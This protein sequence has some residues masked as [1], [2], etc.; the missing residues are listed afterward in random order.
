MTKNFIL[1]YAS[2]STGEIGGQANSFVD[3]TLQRVR[4]S[5]RV[6]D[7]GT[8]KMQEKEDKLYNIVEQYLP[9]DR[10]TVKVTG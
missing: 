6:K 7:I 3:S 10:Y 1:K 8:K 4:L 9:N 5:F 2:Q